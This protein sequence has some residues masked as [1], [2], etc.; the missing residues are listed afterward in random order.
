MRWLIP[1]A[2]PAAIAISGVIV[3]VFG[4]VDYDAHDVLSS[5]YWSGIGSVLTVWLTR[6][7]RQERAS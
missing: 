1:V 2:V 6:P 7:K 4:I 5:I 3:S